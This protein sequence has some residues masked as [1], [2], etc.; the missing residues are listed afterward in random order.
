MKRSGVFMKA[1]V[2][3]L[4][5]VVLYAGVQGQSRKERNDAKAAVLKSSIDSQSYVFRAQMVMPMGGT[6]RQLTSDYD[7]RVGKDTIWC[8]LPYF[9]RAYTAPLDA[10]NGGIKFTSTKFDYK[11]SVGKKGGWNILIKPSD[12]GDVQQLFLSVSAGGYANL[13]VTDVNKQ[14]ISFSGYVDVRKPVQ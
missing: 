13:Q 9:G 8:Y 1:G 12:A 10:S 6:S 7:V 14:P 2:L 11:M 4:L 5:C 3:L